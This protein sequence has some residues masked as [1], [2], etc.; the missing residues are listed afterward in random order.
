[1]GGPATAGGTNE[2]VGTGR[3]SNGSVGEPCGSEHAPGLDKWVGRPG[4]DPGTLGL[5]VPCSSG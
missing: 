2:I 5:K 3:G 4:L 1:M